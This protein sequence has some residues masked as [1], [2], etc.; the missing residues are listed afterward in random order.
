VTASSIRPGEIELI[1]VA[2]SAGTAMHHRLE[3]SDR[4]NLFTTSGGACASVAA[5]LSLRHGYPP[6]VARLG[7]RALK[8]VAA[9][10][11]EIHDLERRFAAGV[12]RHVLGT[13]E[14]FDA[15]GPIEPGELAAGI[16]AA[17]RERVVHGCI[18]VALIDGE[19]S[20]AELAILDG[21]AGVLD[22]P[23]DALATA[24][25]LVDEHL[26]RFRIDILRRS[27]FGQ[28]AVDFVKQR[29]IRG[30]VSVIGNLLQ[31]ENPAIAARYRALESF[32]E[33][34]LGRGYFDFVTRNHFSFPGEKGAGPE[35]IVLH[36]CLHVLAEYDTSS[37][38]ETQ[39]A[40]FQAGT[41]QKGAIYGLLFPLAQFHLGVAITPVTKAETDV[42]DPEPWIKAFVRGTRTNRDLASSWQPWD[43]FA[44][45]VTELRRE[46]G[47][48]PR[49]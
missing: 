37:I 39:I 12:Q 13:D 20:P 24:H 3:P 19:A 27:F 1:D 10:D 5:R 33:G 49:M 38:E 14:D 25:K 28:R 17:F 44:R 9:A 30:L 8:T 31:I 36:D 6:D 34:S 40:A 16:P 29:G 46:Y 2:F 4:A 35:P 41:M 7:L 32:P 11:G 45:P 47:I 43:D 18:L 26:L 15:L 21:F 48:E 42:I 22:V 23:R